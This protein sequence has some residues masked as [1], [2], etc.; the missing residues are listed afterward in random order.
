M[1]ARREREQQPRSPRRQHQPER[2][3]DQRERHTLGEHLPDE[4]TT[5]PAPRAMRTAISDSRAAVRPSMRLATFA[6]AMSITKP[7]AASRMIERRSNV[8]D[9]VVT[10]RNEARADSRVVPRVLRLQSPRD[11]GHFSLR[12]LRRDAAREPADDVDP[13]RPATGIGQMSR[14]ENRVVSHMSTG[15]GYRMSAGATPITWSDS[16]RV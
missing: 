2:A 1:S 11:R 3:P 13:P 16:R 12:L 14:W 10:Q 4:S 5:R 7:T 9:H 8:A 15:D 6:H